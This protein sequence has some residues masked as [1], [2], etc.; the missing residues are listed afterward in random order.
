MASIQVI[1]YEEAEGEVK[2]VYD[3]LIQKR[4][5]LSQVLQIQSLHPATIKS[6]LQ[7]YLDIMFA[8]SPLSRAEREMIAVVVSAANQCTYCQV[9]HTTALLHYWKDKDK[10]EGLRKD[11]TT[12]DL[13][14]KE[15]AMCAYAVGL[16]VH[17]QAQ[18]QADFTPELRNVGLSDRAILDVTLVTAY[19]N[20]VNRMVLSLGVELEENK[21][22]GYSY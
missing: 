1:S 18:A 10:V 8:Q 5:G 21:G 2:A 9:H 12:A 15:K 13:S 22:E 7:L 4:G 14:A 20:F 6:H 19:F 16:T 11:F 3:E 17:P